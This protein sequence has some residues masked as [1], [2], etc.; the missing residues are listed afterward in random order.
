MTNWSVGSSPTF[1]ALAM[2]VTHF[3]MKSNTVS[4]NTIKSKVVNEENNSTTLLAGKVFLW[5]SG[6]MD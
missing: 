3:E 6:A 2:V 4:A 5:L 1:S